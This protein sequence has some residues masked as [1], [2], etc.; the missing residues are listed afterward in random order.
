M[1]KILIFLLCVMLSA[2]ICSCANTDQFISVSEDMTTINYNGAEYKQLYDLSVK[3]NDFELVSDNPTIEGRGVFDSGDGTWMHIYTVED[4][5][6]GLFL[7]AYTQDMASSLYCRS[8]KAEEVQNDIINAS[9]DCYKFEGRD[10][11]GKSY[12]IDI[13]QSLGDMFKELISDHDAYVEY[14]SIKKNPSQPYVYL[15][16][17]S[18]GEFF[19]IYMGFIFAAE[20]GSLYILS[21]YTDEKDESFIPFRAYLIDPMYYSEISQLVARD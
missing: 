5:A 17:F 18:S 10:A 12:S 19:S 20:D 15:Y 11:A 6:D 21:S 8:D 9:F 13:S 1:R 14:D 7:H 3:V 2:G 16:A 4:D